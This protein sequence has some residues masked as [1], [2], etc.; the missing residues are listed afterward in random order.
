[1]AF[2]QKLFNNNKLRR[3]NQARLPYNESTT[4]WKKPHFDAKS[5]RLVLF[6]D[7][8]TK[9]R[10]L[11][12]DSKALVRE[13]GKCCLKKDRSPHKKH[14]SDENAIKHNVSSK[15]CF[16]YQP[17]KTGSDKKKL[18]E[19]M[20]GALGVAYKGTSFKVHVTRSPPQLMITKVFVPE[21]P[22]K[23]MAA[24]GECEDNSF[25]SVTDIANPIPR[26][27]SISQGSES[28]PVDVPSPAQASWRTSMDMIDEDSGLA[29]LTSLTSSGSFQGSYS[30]SRGS[31][32]AKRIIRGQTTSLDGH[33]RR[34]S[35]QDNIFLEFSASKMPKK[36]K[37]AIACI[38]D[39]LSE[40]G[41]KTSGLFESFFFS[42]IALFES[43]LEQMR[44][45]IEQTYYC[46]SKHAFYPVIIEAY[47]HFYEDICDLYTAPRLSEP[48]WLNMMSFTNYRYMLCDKFLKEFVSLVNKF[49]SRN[50][51]FFMSSLVTAVLTHH[52]AWVPT[53]MP[54]GGSP[55]GS[56]L[57]KNSAK[58]VDSLAKSHPYNPLWAQLGDLYGAIGFPLKL[59]RTVIVGKKAEVV[60]KFLFVLSYFIRCS[61]IIESSELGCLETYIESLTFKADTPSD[62]VKT[63]SN[64]VP[65]SSVHSDSPTPVNETRGFVFHDVGED[66]PKS[67]I[68][69]PL[70]SLR[71]ESSSGVDSVSSSEILDCNSNNRKTDLSQPCEACNANR[72]SDG[73]VGN[74]VF[75][76]PIGNCVCDK[77]PRTSG[78][79]ISKGIAE[80]DDARKSQLKLK[81]GNLKLILKVPEDENLTKLSE[82]RLSHVQIADSPERE[83]V[84][85]SRNCDFTR[86]S[87]YLLKL[88]VA[89]RD[90]KIPEN[91][92]KVLSKKEITDIFQ[93]KGSN[94]MFDGYFDDDTIEVKTIDELDEGDRIVDLP[95]HRH[96][97]QRFFSG[98]ENYD[99]L[100]D[101][102][103][104]KAPS[105]PDLTSMKSREVKT[106]PQEGEWASRGRLGSLEN[107]YK[108]RRS[109]MSK[110]LSEATTKIGRHRPV[111]PTEH[112]RRHVSSNSNH[113]LDIVDPRTYCHELP[114]PNPVQENSCSSQ[115]QFNK[116]FGRSLLADFSDHYMSNFV[117]HG[118]SDKDHLEKLNRDIRMATQYSVLD[119]PIA[120]AV[121]VVADT[122]TCQVKVYSSQDMELPGKYPQDCL[123]STLV[124]KL[125]ESIVN[126]A[127]LKMSP[128]FC[129]MH[130][131]DRLQEIYFK[132]KIMAEYLKKKKNVKDMLVMFEF[133]RS[134]L[135]L[136]AAITGTHTPNFPLVCLT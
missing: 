22:K 123:C 84:A 47:E 10:R 48:M 108:H 19:I 128:E 98:G 72:L 57:D 136:L 41:E 82:C 63:V 112:K 107:P 37:I 109:S 40:K 100:S 122:D 54:A 129:I 5:L 61:D 104:F 116:N 80:D 135:P 95:K 70:D 66:S 28:S 65:R 32:Y 83:H 12:F 131:E 71:Y 26:G 76:V 50:T 18:E 99:S 14:S 78:D 58:W 49:E 45:E 62:S 13:D 46:G 105:L 119:E 96:E 2:I 16:S 29:S 8:D 85:F 134:D 11:V 133:D 15:K 52:L 87:D 91:A 86:T 55:T 132:S 43:H 101:S 20:F 89:G 9:G 67:F 97:K 127:R 73:K 115:K 75:Y 102:D 1:M 90:I 103:P 4:D 36:V 118:T 51:N 59:S 33:G 53:V 27:L 93:H 25:S 6:I 69:L 42:H 77:S 24:A 38:F 35:Q 126:M 124:T 34:G 68:P 44:R 130:L 17:Q 64:S 111:T 60:K 113:E 114:M 125:V 92:Q 117:L 30:G 3:Q 31:N 23:L 121:I 21:K 94:S 81:K 88:P 110:Q 120:E 79:E 7:S 74:S 56:Y 39:T 106:T